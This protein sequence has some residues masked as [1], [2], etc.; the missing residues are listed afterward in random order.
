M[1]ILP[2]GAW[3]VAHKALPIDWHGTVRSFSA[4]P[5]SR[6]TASLAGSFV[7][8]CMLG[9]LDV[10]ASRVIVAKRVSVKRA[11]FAGAVSHAFSNTLGFPALTGSLIRYRVYASAGLGG[12]D[13]ARIVTL[14]AFG[15]AMGFTVVTT[16]A[17]LWQPALAHGWGRPL[18]IWL[19]AAL[20]AFLF[21]LRSTH[22]ALHIAR[23]TL[24]FP[25]SATAACQMAV[26]G[27]EM[28]A[29]IGALYVLLPSG[30]APPFMDFVPIYVGAVVVGLISH[31]PGGLGVFETV[32]LA[33]FPA[34]ARPDAL[35]AMLCYRLTY[36]VAPFSLACM[37]WIGF[38]LRSFGQ[39]K[40]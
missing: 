14:A 29:A 12:G 26:G 25:D 16:L 10:L 35:A 32:V 15:V 3:I 40:C 30:S 8:F 20:I 33:A 6:I 19:G 39:P 5:F 11:A 34:S 31:V 23:W 27:V 7:S 38:E 9:W 4:I 22:R 1:T 18:G 37:G 17:M 13:I 2:V 28:L 21:W 24:A 36:S